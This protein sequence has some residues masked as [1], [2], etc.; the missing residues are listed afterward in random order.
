[1]R[2]PVRPLL[3]LGVLSAGVALM[4]WAGPTA[5]GAQAPADTTQAAGTLATGRTLHAATLLPDGRVL[6]LGGIEAS[7]LNT[8]SVEAYDPAD[9]GWQPIG[10]LTMPRS[11]HTATL[12]ADG[13]SILVTGGS[14]A[15]FTPVAAAEI[16]ET[17]S[18]RAHAVAALTAPRSSHTATRLVDGRV[19]VAGGLTGGAGTETAAADLY[20]PATEEF[21]GI[22]R[23]AAPR[24]GHTATLLPDGRVLVAGGAYFDAGS[25][26]VRV[27]G[28]E[29]FD[30][31]GGTFSPAP[32]M[33]TPRS[34]HTATLLADGSVLIVGGVSDPLRGTQVLAAERFDPIANRFVAAGPLASGRAGHTATLL[35][36]GSVLVVGDGASAVRWDPAQHAFVDGATIAPDRAGHTAVRLADGSVLVAGGTG[37]STFTL[38]RNAFRYVPAPLPVPGRAIPLLPGWNLVGLPV[39]GEIRALLAPIA[40]DVDSVFTWAADA[41]A[42]RDYHPALPLS[43]NSLQTVQAGAGA[44]ILVRNPLGALWELPALTGPREVSLLPGYNLV[45]WS[46]P[47]G[48][49]VA[50]AIAPLGEAFQSLYRWDAERQR[51]QSARPGGLSLFNDATTLAHGEGV[52]IRVSRA[53]IWAQPAP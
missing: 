8:A 6:V 44:W 48:T 16:V 13:T 47:D 2:R 39:S 9:G 53:V 17:A 19:L 43:L 21:V 46:G 26:A 27:A 3:R 15:P 49:A 11:G 14:S 1:M 18:G 4:A 12:L 5:L 7:G 28:A 37:A 10:A 29:L 36:D 52:W 40:A 51:Y 50:S 32:P 41:Q 20:Q 22:G 30:P 23:M 31:L 45:L 35:A 24:A 34:D 25:G 42:Y 38:L 33:R